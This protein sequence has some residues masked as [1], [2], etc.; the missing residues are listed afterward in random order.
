M[1]LSYVVAPLEPE[2]IIINLH[3]V[4]ARYVTNA[5]SYDI[6]LQKRSACYATRWGK[7]KTTGNGSSMEECKRLFGFAAVWG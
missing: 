2:S 4:T 1:A 7:A 3:P 5:H 6:L